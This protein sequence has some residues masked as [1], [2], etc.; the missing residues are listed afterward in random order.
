MMSGLIVGGRLMAVVNQLL[1]ERLHLEPG[2]V[3]L[4]PHLSTHL[5]LCQSADDKS[6]SKFK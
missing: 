4:L 6:V 3:A 1:V 5:Q 2:A